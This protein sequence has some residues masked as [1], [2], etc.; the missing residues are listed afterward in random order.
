[1]E[2]NIIKFQ[3]E[4][5]FEE[6]ENI[7]KYL[8]DWDTIITDSRYA[9]DGSIRLQSKFFDY[10]DYTIKYNAATNTA[11]DISEPTLLEASVWLYQITGDET[12][13]ANAGHVA[14]AIEEFY[15]LLKNQCP[16]Q[17]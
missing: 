5:D 13:L 1:M 16:E 4:L 7:E 8:L 10:V 2:N 14:N 9:Y 11:Y 12:Y 6:T 3:S 17:M 15:F